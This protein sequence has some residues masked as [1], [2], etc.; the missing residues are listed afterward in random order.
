M[1]SSKEF[2]P[3]M[4]R[5]LFLKL[6]LAGIGSL[7]AEGAVGCIPNLLPKP[8]QSEHNGVTFRVTTEYAPVQKVNLGISLTSR[9]GNSV[10]FQEEGIVLPREKRIV[11]HPNL[12]VVSQSETN[13]LIVSST[14]QR[15]ISECNIES[16]PIPV[17]L[18]L[19]DIP[20]PAVRGPFKEDIG[21]TGSFPE[22][23]RIISIVSL[24]GVLDQV[25]MSRAR[26]GQRLSEREKGR[27]AADMM[28]V[29]SEYIGHE[30]FHAGRHMPL[31]DPV[32]LQRY[33]ELE[34]EAK[35]YSRRLADR[36]QFKE[37]P[38]IAIIS[39]LPS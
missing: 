39:Q 8:K 20:L 10:V 30:L 24:K 16:V 26:Q 33:D 23:K 4:T 9:E 5:R 19:T 35:S 25:E 2:E 22:Y 21:V 29:L 15:I 34:E 31:G 36:V 28:Y 11:V 1:N 6:S 3:I 18:L 13:P 17:L 12:E 38:P 14:I 37:I 27:I 32:V 7:V